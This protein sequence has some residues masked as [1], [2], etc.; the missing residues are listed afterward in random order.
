MSARKFAPVLTGA[1]RGKSF[2][3]SLKG[4]EV[5]Q[6]Q[7]ALAIMVKCKAHLKYG[8]TE[9]Q[10]FAHALKLVIR[11]ILRSGKFYHLDEVEFHQHIDAQFAERMDKKRHYDK[12][13]KGR[14]MEFS[15]SLPPNPSN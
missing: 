1:T 13:K 8:M 3:F 2:S 14:F 4:P 10:F 15:Y 6:L 9:R 12:K 5:D 7:D 11:A